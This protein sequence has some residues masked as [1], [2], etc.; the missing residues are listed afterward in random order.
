MPGHWRNRFIWVSLLSQIFEEEFL[1]VSKGAGTLIA[2]GVESSLE[3]KKT[4]MK[5]RYSNSGR[6]YTKIL[7]GL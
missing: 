6:S 2:P 1:A 4:L 3:R 7:Q 5:N